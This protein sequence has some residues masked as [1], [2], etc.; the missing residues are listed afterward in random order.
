LFGDG[1]EEEEDRKEEKE[2]VEKEEELIVAEKVKEKTKEIKATLQ[3][4]P[5]KT[6][7][8]IEEF[9]D[10]F[11]QSNPLVIST[12]IITGAVAGASVVLSNAPMLPMAATSN[13]PTIQRFALPFARRKRK[14]HW[15]IVFDSYSKR[16]IENV[17]VLLINEEKGRVIERTTTD[18]QGRYGFLITESGKLKI[19][20]RKRSYELNTKKEKDSFYEDVYT[21]PILFKK[22]TPIKVNIKMEYLGKGIKKQF[23]EFIDRNIFIVSKTANYAMTI[24]YIVGFL[25]SI[26]M[27]WQYPDPINYIIFLFYLLSSIYSVFAKSKK[28]FGIIKERETKKP[29]PF[30]LI[31]LYDKNNRRTDF[32]VTD[33]LGRYYLLT[34][35]GEY[36]YKVSAIGPQRKQIQTEGEVKITEEIFKRDFWF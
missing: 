21:E 4:T 19:G 14:K 17:E 8:K 16:P 18:K 36:H 30:S 20:A 12:T 2:E 7:N 9:A 28:S 23:K 22:E 3:Q 27:I 1:E 32:A 35:N 5:Q 29:L 13:S 15:G 11:I 26:I 25:T 31:E 34:D 33:T 10:T 6:K 24:L